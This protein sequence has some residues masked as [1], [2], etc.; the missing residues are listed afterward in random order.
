[1]A[2]TIGLPWILCLGVNPGWG[3]GFSD[4]LG[5]ELT[6]KPENQWNLSSLMT[7]SLEEVFSKEY[8]GAL[9]KESRGYLLGRQKHQVSIHEELQQKLPTRLLGGLDEIEMQWDPVLRR[10]NY[11]FFSSVTPLVDARP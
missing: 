4:G 11:P 9:P 5:C 6:L 7:K 2:D 3:D 10:V 8:R 1:M